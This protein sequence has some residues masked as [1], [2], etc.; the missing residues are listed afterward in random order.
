[1]LVKIVAL[2][3]LLLGGTTAGASMLEDEIV[4][5][6]TL[7][8]TEPESYARFIEEFR[9][10]FQGKYYTLPDVENTRFVT[11]EGTSAIDEAIAYLRHQ[12]AMGPLSSSK[13]L[14]KA[15]RDLAKEQEKTG[16][17]GHV[18]KKS[19]DVRTRIERHG[20]WETTIGENI[21]YG[22]N[23]ARMVVMQL[24]IDD[25]VKS[26]GHRKN[27]FNPAFAVAGVACGPHPTLRI[28]C[29]IDYAGGYTP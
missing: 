24:I 26:R 23:E 21:A 7:A 29:V 5:E 10:R 9:T 14:A 17:T 15:A 13:E 1:M 6:M 4:Q 28:V 16:E 3:M 11:H 20:R 12:K 22:P 8:R 19:G 27:I 25:G 18:G 2:M